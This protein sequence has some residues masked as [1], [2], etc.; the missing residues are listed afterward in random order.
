MLGLWENGDQISVE[1]SIDVHDEGG[2][3]E[4]K[5]TVKEGGA[6]VEL[7]TDTEESKQTESESTT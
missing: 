4:T 1:Y 5:T 2:D 3:E 6:E 7:K